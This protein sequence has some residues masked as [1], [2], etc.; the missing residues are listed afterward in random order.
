MKFHD[1]Q[2]LTAKDVKA[3]IE[4]AS[5]LNADPKAALP[6][7]ANWGWPQEGTI[8]DDFTVRFAGKKPFGP[9]LNTLAYTDIIAASDIAKGK[10]SLEKHPNGTGAFKLTDDKPNVKTLDRFDDHYRGPAKIRQMTWEFIKDAQTRLNAI[11]AGQAEVVDRVVP[12]QRSLIEA[13]SD[14]KLISVTAPEIQSI[15]FRMD[16]DPIAAN[17]G[18]RKAMAWGLDRESMA[19]LVGGKTLVADS[20]LAAGIEYRAA[21]SPL[22]SFDPDKAKA[23]LAKAGGGVAFEIAAPTGFYPKA[24]EICQL[25]KQNLDEV[26]FKTKLTLLELAAWIDMLF[27]KSKP[28]EAFYGGWGNITRDPDFAVATL[29]HSPG[30]WTGAHDAKSD[31]LIDAG[32]TSSKSEERAKIYGDLQAHLWSD[33][34]PSIPILYS[35]LSAAYRAN[36][37][38]FQVFPTAVNDFWP[39]E[40]T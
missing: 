39:V 19:A 23:E 13:S 40:I 27:G 22:Y 36:V 21:Q 18:L 20:H 6:I 15:W 30:A 7:T 25:I 9:M 3:S 17:L 10:E 2:P 37:Q 38:G 35:D 16:K 29:L 8:V 24:E 5:G 31:Q 1:G 26:G 33:L 34:L 28:G 14:T 11:L 32:K 12:D 4:L